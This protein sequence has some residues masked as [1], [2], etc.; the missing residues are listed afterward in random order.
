MGF[1]PAIL[2]IKQSQ[3]Y[4]LDR[5]ADEISIWFTDRWSHKNLVLSNK[6]KWANFKYYF[7]L[8]SWE[9]FCLHVITIALMYT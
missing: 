9:H 2:A 6:Q 4:A 7:G 1:E 3:T 5:T 8:D